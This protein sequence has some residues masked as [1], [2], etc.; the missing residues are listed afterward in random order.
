LRTVGLPWRREQRITQAVRDGQ[1]RLHPER[2]L[3]VELKFIG[4]KAPGYRSSLG[5]HGSSFGVVVLRVQ[6][7]EDA[8]QGN[9][10]PVVIEIEVGVDSW[11][12]VIPRIQR[13]GGIGDAGSIQ[14]RGIG[15]R[16]AERIQE[17][18][19]WITNEAHVGAKL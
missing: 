11:E 14:T 5:Q 1:V 17:I 16:I 7:A 2:I 9:D 3:G 15:K 12:A 4:S 6:L 10:G 19:F 13:A 8:R 18:R